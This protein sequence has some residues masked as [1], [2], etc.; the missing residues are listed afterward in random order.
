[1]KT[2]LMYE[3]GMFTGFGERRSMGV[4]QHFGMGPHFTEPDPEILFT[5]AP[6][7]DTTVVFLAHF[8]G[9]SAAWVADPIYGAAK[10][11]KLLPVHFQHTFAINHLAVKIHS[12]RWREHPVSFTPDGFEFRHPANFTHAV[13]RVFPASPAP[14][15]WPPKIAFS[16]TT[17]PLLAEWKKG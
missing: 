16:D 12:F 17:L 10:L 8:V 15:E 7:P 9:P 6:V 13:V 4:G 5:N 1:M 14:V 11:P 3:H 2:S